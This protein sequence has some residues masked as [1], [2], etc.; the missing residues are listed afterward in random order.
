MKFKRRFWVCLLFIVFYGSFCDAIKINEVRWGFSGKVLAEK[1]NPLYVEILNEKAQPFDGELVLERFGFSVGM[2]G[3]HGRLGAKLSVHCY[4]MPRSKR[5]VKF[6]PYVNDANDEWRLN[7]EEI[8]LP[9]IGLPAI[10]YLHSENDYRRVKSCF[11]ILPEGFL[12]PSVALMDGL[13]TIILDYVPKLTPN[14]AQ[15]LRDWVY[16][17]GNVVVCQTNRLIFSDKLSFL[18]GTG[19]VIFGGG[20]IVHTSLLAK[21]LTKKSLLKLG[22]K[23]LKQA[24]KQVQEEDNFGDNFYDQRMVFVNT[25]FQYLKKASKHNYNW[26]V[27][28]VLSVIYLLLMSV[29]SYLVFRKRSSGVL[30]LGVT[31]GLIA[32][33]TFVFIH[34]GKRGYGEKTKI[35]TFTYAKDLGDG[36]YAL[37]QWSS[38]FVVDGDNYKL[39]HKGELDYY[40]SC[41]VYEKIYGEIVNGKNGFYQLD[42]PMF[43]QTSVLHK[44]VMNGE[45]MRFGL[46]KSKGIKFGFVIKLAKGMDDKRFK[47]K[48]ALFMMIYKGYVYALQY[49]AI[50]RCFVLLDEGG[51]VHDMEMNLNVDQYWDD[52]HM[53]EGEEQFNQQ[54]FFANVT[55]D[56]LIYSQGGDEKIV[57]GYYQEQWE[58]KVQLLLFLSSKKDFKFSKFPEKIQNSYVLYH[59]FLNPS[60]CFGETNND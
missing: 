15:A 58:N 23:R 29:G 27:I 52:L 28:F 39:Q 42:I 3:G 30:A 22:I 32:L 2:G 47:D 53:R 54:Q 49:D 8:K 25:V 18:N 19:T 38:I 24:D 17:G 43:T 16:Q 57:G 41:Q 12:P 60:S 36:R 56:L 34:I 45:V 4:I 50:N 11:P 35:T 46:Q 9:T 6:Y 55:T 37:T 33:F 5:W 7:G 44:G 1:V 10:V 48:N 21:N 40:S 20:T 26:V 59:F 13:Y 31:L 14:K 51:R